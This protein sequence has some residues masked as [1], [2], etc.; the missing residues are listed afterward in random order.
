M[1]KYILLF[2]TVVMSPS[3]LL[4]SDKSAAQDL[5]DAATGQAS[6]LESS[7]RPFEMNV[8]FTAQFDTPIQ[9]H[10]RLKWEAKDR[11]WSKVTVGPFEQV[12][13]QDGEKTYTMR[14]TDFT[15]TP[16]RDLMEL[17]HVAKN[18]DKLVVRKDKQYVDQGVTLDCMQTE[19]RGT[20][21]D[22]PPP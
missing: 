11:W 6:L 13:F 10:L 21:K 4:A 9:G 5:L 7:P 1:I 8:D 2:A 3:V 17:L 15:P 18:F 22:A 20:K 12:K 14:N 19:R 16:V